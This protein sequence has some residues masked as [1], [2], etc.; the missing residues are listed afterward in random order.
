MS[1]DARWLNIIW[2]HYKKKHNYAKRQVELFLHEE[3]I[4]VWKDMNQ[5]KIELRVMGT[6]HPHREN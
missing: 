3:E 4:L 2:K 6:T 1:R 5:W